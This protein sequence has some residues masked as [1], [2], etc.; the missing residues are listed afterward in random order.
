VITLRSSPVRAE[1]GVPQDAQKRA[2]GGRSAPHE[3]QTAMSKGYGDC[4]RDAT[5]IANDAG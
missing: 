3:R 4:V 5:P 2:A 1:T